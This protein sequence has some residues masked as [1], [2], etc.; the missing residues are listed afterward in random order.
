MHMPFIFYVKKLLQYQLNI[1]FVFFPIFFWH[2]FSLY[3]WNL[4]CNLV[5]VVVLKYFTYIYSC[6]V[7]TFKTRPQLIRGM[8][9]PRHTHTYTANSCCIVCARRM[10]LKVCCGMCLHRSRHTVMYPSYLPVGSRLP[11]NGI[12]CGMAMCSPAQPLLHLSLF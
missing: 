8:H 11:T 1:C 12:K 6:V 10:Y 9:T 5:Q 7:S 2:I 3:I 4:C